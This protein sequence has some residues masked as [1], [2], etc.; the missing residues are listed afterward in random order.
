MS[1]FSEAIDLLARPPGDLVYFLVT[2]FALQQA[3]LPAAMARRAAP[4][5]P[6]PR[7]WLWAIGGMLAGRALLISFGFLGLADLLPAASWLPPLERLIEVAG[8]ALVWWALWGERAARWQTW[9][10]AVLLLVGVGFFAYDIRFWLLQAVQGKAYNITFG[11]WIWELA[12]LGLLTLALVLQL[13]LRPAEWEWAVGLLVIWLVGHGAQLGWADTSLHISGWGRLTALVV[14]PL[15]ATFVQRALFAGGAGVVR[16]ER[17]TERPS[18]RQLKFSTAQPLDF[19]GFQTFFEGI[20]SARELEPALMVASSRLARLLDAELCVIALPE[21]LDPPHLRVVAQ[22]PPAGALE[23]PVLELAE[24]DMLEEAW[25]AREYRLIQPARPPAWLGTLFS[26]FGFRKPGPLAALPLRSGE[27]MVGMLLLGNP[28]SERRWT[29][30]ALVI[31]QLTATLLG[32]AIDRAQRQGGSIFSLRESTE[33][34]EVSLTAA[35]S[36]IARLSERMLALQVE[37]EDRGREIARLHVRLEDQSQPASSTEIDFWQNEVRELARD[38]D[39]LILE[40]NRL[41]QE[42]AKTRSRMEQLVDERRGFVKQLE[43]LNAQL[44]AA[45][46]T[47]VGMLLGL[48]V[49]DE[50]GMIVMADALARQLLHLP[51]G[52]V[53]GIPL[54][55]AYPDHQWAAA[56]DELLS[57]E[58]EARRRIHLTLPVDAHTVEADLVALAGRDGD[59]DALVVTLRTEESFAERQEALTGIANEF[60]TP[61]TSITGY[62][63]LLLG[64]QAGIL[65]E[66]Q[67]QFLERV[68][69]NVEQM[70]QLLNDLVQIASPDA[71]AVELT[72]EPM[73]LIGIIEE[74]IMGLAARFRERKLAVRMDLPPQL[75]PIRA[76]RDSLYQIMLRLLSN[77]ALC[78]QVGTEVVVS[79]EAQAPEGEKPPYIRIS[80]VDTGGG[81]AAE[82]FQKVFRRFYRAGQPLVAGMGEKGVGMAVAKTLVEAN[83]GRIWVETQP[84]VGS[85]FSFILPA[86]QQGNSA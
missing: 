83:G 71:R 75:L 32:G 50:D 77:A 73:D 33:D 68:R 54:D 3:L 51:Q 15:L 17:P 76:D 57:R 36:E 1:I 72:P 44:Q 80:V 43:T 59:T 40:R 85:T 63:A 9:L 39:V 5:A 37:L 24:F 4:D 18:R 25:T 13:A 86:Y 14:L 42:L 46:E 6:A 67:Q 41:G 81:I 48:L 64:E 47:P 84:G 10:L 78:S 7:R 45:Q 38:R 23:Y 70:G 53:A 34:F 65:T 11:A 19:N 2:L 27:K 22:H 30:E 55:G 52:E 79:G 69:A 35:Q 60:R 31:P 49:A 61:M 21:T 58:P 56:I 29:P 62:T 8:I 16:T 66:M 74:G 28:D 20:E 12:A 26:E 82:D